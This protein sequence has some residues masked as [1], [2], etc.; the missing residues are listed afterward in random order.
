MIYR[1]SDCVLDQDA[2]TLHVADALCHVEPRVFD[3]ILFFVKNEGRI[4]CRDEIVENVWGGRIVSDATI[5][6]CVKAARQALGDD[7]AQQKLIRTVRGRGFKF[8]AE[9]RATEPAAAV[10][11]VLPG[12][13][14]VAD[15]LP[16]P[17]PRPQGRPSIAVLPL[18]LLTP[19][20]PHKTLGDAVSH[21]VILEL[22]RLHWLFVIARGSSFSFR[23]PDPDLR[24][25][26]EVLGVRYLLTGTLSIDDKMSV[27]AV[28]LAQGS[29][30][31]IIW[32]ERFEQP[33]SEL[34]FLRSKIAASIVGAVEARIR[35]KE[36]IQACR[37]STE[38]LDAWS[39]YHRGLWHMFR[40]T[41]KDNAAAANLFSHAVREDPYFAR[42]HAGL[43]FTHF[44]NAFLN[45][46]MDR[47]K[48]IGLA[49]KYAEE[50]Y[51]LDPFDPFVNLTLGRA[52]WIAGDLKATEP[53]LGRAIDLNPNYAFAIYNKALL[54]VLRGEGETSDSEVGKAMALSPVD[55]LAYAM[56]A[57]R[58]M[59]L[60]LREDF[61][62]ASEWATRAIRAP[63]AH[64]QIFVVAAIAYER[65]GQR[66]LAE[67]C[68]AR[69][70]AL[71]P[72]FRQ[73][74]FFSA[75]PFAER[76]FSDM[77]T[78]TLSGLGLRK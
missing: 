37:I 12:S 26:S 6:S 8:L 15:S 13:E 32:A 28:E 42:A 33:L 21:E 34:M 1:F 73:S 19:S 39:A 67:Q 65:S 77:A 56:L 70:M 43:S 14:P 52:E 27:V 38:N 10:A 25:I 53:W 78:T 16:V 59:A 17:G 46:S 68:V 76:V 9:V 64:F 72:D 55:P 5:S 30:G 44:Q 63:N 7:G 50:S 41:Q 74:D 45:F 40:F 24:S 62:S 4:V 49:R 22:S 66:L 61:Q 20:E 29:D 31:Q 58:S 51:D 75:F 71:K 3:L 11:S 23:S 60:M 2:F 69:I 57:T 47:S 36:A 48:D 35:T 18:Q 54:G